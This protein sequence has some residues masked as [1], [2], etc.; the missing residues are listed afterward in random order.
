MSVR[1]SIEHLA[2]ESD[3]F[4]LKT[5]KL[6]FSPDAAPLSAADFAPYDLVQAKISAGDN[7]ALDGLSA[8]GFSLAESEVDFALTLKSGTENAVSDST[9]YYADETDIPVIKQAA[10]QVF[11]QSRFR[12]PWY[13]PDDSARFYAVWA[14]K[15]VRGTFDKDC[16]LIRNKNN[17]IAGFVTLRQTDEHSARIGLLAVLPGNQGQGIGLTLMSA[18]QQWCA[19]HHCRVLRVATQLSNLAAMRLYT[20]SGGAVDSTAYWLYRGCNDSI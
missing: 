13:Q 19:E 4:A 2:W 8:L 1:A 9:L 16:L 6:A 3:F 12:A 10:A 15:A 20:K 18:A 7:A 11:S 17:E 5:A 14:E